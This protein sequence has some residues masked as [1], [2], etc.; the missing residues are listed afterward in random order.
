MRY[1]FHRNRPQPHIFTCHTSIIEP[2]RQMYMDEK[3]K[4]E[5]TRELMMDRFTL[6]L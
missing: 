5:K 6:A 3:G 1:L 2:S 4:C